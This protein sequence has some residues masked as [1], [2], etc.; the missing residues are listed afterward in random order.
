M[1]RALN[2]KGLTAF[3][4]QKRAII[5]SGMVTYVKYGVWGKDGFY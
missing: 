2:P 3:S 1:A 4:T 5:G